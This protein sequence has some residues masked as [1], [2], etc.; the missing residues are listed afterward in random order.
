MD[1]P[2]KGLTTVSWQ[3]V[4]VPRCQSHAFFIIFYYQ[5]TGFFVVINWPFKPF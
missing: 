4:S 5:P 2:V 1:N 3:Q